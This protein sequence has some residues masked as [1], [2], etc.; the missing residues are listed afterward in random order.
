MNERGRLQRLLKL[1]SVFRGKETGVYEQLAFG[2]YKRANVFM[3]V[4]GEIDDTSIVVPDRC[5]ATQSIVSFYF[6]TM[7]LP[8]YDLLGFCIPKQNLSVRC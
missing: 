3:R 1:L 8:G 5:L 2:R 4:P 7:K 6:S